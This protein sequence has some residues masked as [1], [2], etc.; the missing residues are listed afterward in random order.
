MGNDPF[1]G[2]A[3]RVF[4]VSISFGLIIL[5]PLDVIPK[6]GAL[7][8]RRRRMHR[9]FV[10][11]SFV[12]AVFRIRQSGDGGVV[13]TEGG[14]EALLGIDPAQFLSGAVSLAAR[15]HPQDADVAARIFSAGEEREGV[16]EEGWTNLRVRHANGKIRCLRAAVRRENDDAGEPVL[17]LTLEDVRHAKGDKDGW[18]LPI[19][20]RTLMESTDDLVY[21]KN[22]HHA[23]IAMNEKVRMAIVDLIGACEPEQRLTDYDLFPEEIADL[24]YKMEKDIFAGKPLVQEIQR[25]V[26]RD[27]CDVW[28]DNRKYPV[29]DEK[30]DVIGLLGMARRITNPTMTV[31]QR[32]HAEKVYEVQRIAGLGSYVLDVT[33]AIWTASEVLEEILGIDRRY[34]RTVEGWKNL[35]HP[36]DR[37]AVVKYYTDEVLGKGKP[38]RG[39]YRI[40]RPVDGAVRW[41]QGRGELDLDASGNV[42]RMHGTIQDV[43][44]QKQVEA[45]LQESRDLLRLF[46]EHAPAA[47]AMLDREM[48]YLAVSRRWLEMFGLTLD[49]VIGRSHYEVLPGSPQEWRKDHVAALSGK[50]LPLETGRLV[51]P[52]G[53]LQWLRREVHPWIMGTGEVGGV[54]LFAEDI[55][56]QRLAEERLHLAASVFTH[57]TEGIVITDAEGTILDVNDAFTRITGYMREEAIGQN[58]RILKSDRQNAEFYEEMWQQLVQHGKWT[59][60]IWNRAKSGRIIAETLTISAVPDESGGVRQYVA[61]FSDLTSVKEQERQLERIAQYDLLTGL[62][63]RTLLVDRKRHAMARAKGRGSVMALICL[64]LD[65]FRAVNDR[66]GHNVG[67][68]LLI[69]VAQRLRTVL[70]AGDTLARPGGDEFV[71]VLPDLSSSQEALPVLAQLQAAAKTPFEVGQHVVQLSASAGVAFYPQPADVDAD[72]LLRQASQAL[73]HAKLEG[74]DCYHVFDPRQDENVR[75]HHEDLERIRTALTSGELALYYQP[76]VNMRTGKVIGAEALI[77]W[78]HPEAGLLLPAQF[79]PVMEGTALAMEVGEWVMECA[80]RQIE[81]WNRQGLDLA[82]SV[83]VSAQQLQSAEFE[84]QLRRLLEKHPG[85]KPHRLEL[86]LLENGALTEMAEVVALIEMCGKMGVAFSLDDFGTGY[87]SLSY[88]RRLPFDALKIDRTFVRDMLDDPEDLTLLEGVLGLATAFRRQPVA[89]GVESV[90]HGMML[91][92][93]GCEQGQGY[94]IARPMPAAEMAAWARAW[95]PYA[96]WQHARTLP[97]ADWPMVHAAVEH[98]AW[99]LA[100]AEYLEGCRQIPPMIE[101]SECRFG[102]WLQSERP[103]AHGDRF[104]LTGVDALHRRIHTVAAE[105]L[106]LGRDGKKEEAAFGLAN[107]HALRDQFLES[108]DRMWS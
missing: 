103:A 64:D 30:G 65:N 96:E 12:Q 42:V 25:R 67:D 87:S 72:Q 77:R 51:R 20:L 38:F 70:R 48:R 60:E 95:R 31:A 26:D 84:G 43:T 68:Q 1:M 62:P 6:A 50:V 76:R 98:R 37:A 32:E 15:I 23:L 7:S 14:V 79:L 16:A 94:G 17:Q 59:G 55:T 101:P 52:D 105:V 27:G 39:E 44:E 18:T 28:M 91:L 99:I 97:P 33:T 100:I 61:L 66:L 5:S 11:E 82:V 102:S 75:G 53:Q 107:L 24:Y 69:A 10:E 57:A 93:L 71:A 106:D 83:N 80:L 89:E 58:P 86:E 45:A 19:H 21:F 36:E 46:I 41:V 29:R 73:Y 3:A 54:I 35:V 40:V 34:P 74:K 56:Q 13:A 90:E 63:N 81:E 78:Q 49:Q 108:L 8:A 2:C 92:R 4:M 47:L 22:R 104:E 85:V 9:L 88:L